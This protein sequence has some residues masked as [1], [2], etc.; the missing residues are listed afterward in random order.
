MDDVLTYSTVQWY[1]Y[2]VI[3]Y[4][5]STVGYGRRGLPAV[6]LGAGILSCTV[7]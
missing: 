2:R 3:Y 7:E 1:F 4:C 6:V 5:L